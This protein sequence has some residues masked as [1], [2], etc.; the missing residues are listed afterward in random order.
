MKKGI[1]I[2]LI[3]LIGFF[4]A[5]EAFSAPPP[6][7]D[8]EGDNTTMIYNAGRVAPDSANAAEN[9]PGGTL[10]SIFSGERGAAIAGFATD[11]D[12][13]RASYGVTGYNAADN[14]NVNGAGVLGV[15]KYA[16]IGS[17]YDFIDGIGVE[18]TAYGRYCV[19]VEGIADNAYDQQGNGI[20]AGVTGISFGGEGPNDTPIGVIGSAVG[21]AGSNHQ[22][23]GVYGTAI[24]N[25]DPN[26]DC[27]GVLGQVYGQKGS[28]VYGNAF[29]ASTIGVYGKNADPNGYAIYSEGKMKVNGDIE[30][31]GSVVQTQEDYKNIARA[32]L[33]NAQGQ[34]AGTATIEIVQWDSAGNEI[35]NGANAQYHTGGYP[36]QNLIDGIYGQWD[37]GEWASNGVKPRW[38]E[39][40][41]WVGIKIKFPVPVYIDKVVLYFRPN[42]VDHI[43]D[44]WL[45]NYNADGRVIGAR[46]GESTVG[47]IGKEVPI[48]E[49]ERENV[50][51]ILLKITNSVEGILN[52]GMAEI[53]CWGREMN[54][55]PAPGA[56]EVL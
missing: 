10:T 26:A 34:S 14:N 3:L 6:L 21:G 35:V 39:Q 19:G 20:P 56:P 46:L 25:N 32:E 4:T 11:V 31:S 54:L 44:M 8:L 47:G 52:A 12:S 13:Q 24:S 53:E 7:Q 36:P 41:S 2:F 18:G 28:G 45:Y 38:N 17:A 50:T 51:T 30:I 16:I 43:L 1:I 23:I 5:K 42:P 49:G 29:R 22:P 33:K 9:M 27:V 40:T 37:R 15:G 55:P 48:P